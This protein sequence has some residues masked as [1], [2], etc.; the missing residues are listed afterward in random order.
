MKLLPK[1]IQDQLQAQYQL[2]NHLEAQKVIAK[3]FN[4]YGRG[5]WYLLNQD[6]EDPDYL[7]AIVDMYEVE[8]G[9]VLKSDLET[10]RL[11]DANLPLERDRYFKPLNAKEAFDKLRAG[12]QL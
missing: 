11:T 4:P 8:I 12:D 6:P 3:I 9:S 7:W 5:T 10:I 2:G 1:N